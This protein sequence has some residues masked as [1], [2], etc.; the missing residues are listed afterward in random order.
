MTKWENYEE[1]ATHLLNRFAADFGLERV[2]G[3]QGIIGYRS[4]T[5]WEIDAKGVRA[6]NTGFIIVECRRYTSS[7][8]NQEKAAAMAYRI[9][10]AGAAGGIIIS[11][12]GLQ[13]GARK[14]SNAENI[15]D[16]HLNEDCNQ[17]EYVMKF[18]NKVMIGLHQELKFKEYLHVEQ[19]DEAGNLVER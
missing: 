13:E 17:H 9:N 4:G 7:R 18:L 16:V 8:Q 11:P 14:V 15:I 10:D 2:E 5:T 6:G 19:F 12:L 3:K 1:V